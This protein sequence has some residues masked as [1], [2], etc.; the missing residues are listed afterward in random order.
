M[1]RLFTLFLAFVFLLNLVG[2]GEESCEHYYEVK[3]EVQATCSSYS[4]TTYACAYCGDTYSETE[5]SYGEHSYKETFVSTAGSCIEKSSKEYKCS[6]C[7][8]EKTVYGDYASHQYKVISTVPATCQQRGSQTEKCSVCHDEKTTYGGYG[9]CSY[10]VT[11]TQS[12]TCQQKSSTTNTCRICGDTRTTYGSYAN[13]SGVKTCTT[14]STSF[15]TLLKNYI[16]SNGTRVSSGSY[17]ITLAT[18]ILGNGKVLMY[19]PTEDY[20]FCGAKGVIG[21]AIFTI[22]NNL[23]YEWSFLDDNDNFIYG[24]INASTYKSGN[25]LTL[26]GAS[27]SNS[28]ANI[29]LDYATS[30]I[31]SLIS[32]LSQKL[33]SSSLRFTIYNL[34]FI[35]Y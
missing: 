26:S 7:N 10:Q 9:S 28:M 20:I 29:L 25:V 23:T 8:D 4:E 1:K 33:S 35:N 13:H 15:Y 17:G 32:L 14:C 5:T 2:C 6:I 31:S 22:N 19:D 11:S 21:Y 16:I 24:D 3:S 18:D 12:A 30:G 34:G 27:C